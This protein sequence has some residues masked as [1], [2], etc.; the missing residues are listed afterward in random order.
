[1][2]SHFE[3]IMLKYINIRKQ[4]FVKLHQRNKA[5]VIENL[6]EVKKRKSLDLKLTVEIKYLYKARV[7]F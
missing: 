5:K 3:S 7:L 1:M 2:L 6:N 4:L